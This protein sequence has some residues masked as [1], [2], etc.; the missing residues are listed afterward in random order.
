MRIT[1]LGVL[2]VLAVGAFLV[3]AGYE[4][5]RITEEKRRSGATLD[6]PQVNP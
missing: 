4:L 6:P 2:G 3:Y 5:H 1:L